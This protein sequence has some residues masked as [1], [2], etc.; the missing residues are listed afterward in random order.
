MIT[1]GKLLE[2]LDS[3]NEIFIHVEYPTWER[4]LRN[5]GVDIDEITWSHRDTFLGWV[6]EEEMEDLGIPFEDVEQLLYDLTVG[7]IV[8]SDLEYA[9][10]VELI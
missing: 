10:G 9:I 7:A 6:N 5:Y 8:G 1:Y 3:F 2:L 4:I